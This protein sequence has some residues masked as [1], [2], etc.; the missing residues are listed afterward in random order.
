LQS[1]LC[2]F[3]RC[4]RGK[5]NRDRVQGTSQSK[6]AG[7]AALCQ[8]THLP[9]LRFGRRSPK[10]HAKRDRNLRAAQRRRPRS[11]ARASWRCFRP[12][13]R[14]D[15][16]RLQSSSWTSR[17]PSALLQEEDAH[18]PATF[19]WRGLR[20][21]VALDFV[22]C[23]V[24]DW[25]KLERPGGRG[26]GGGTCSDCTCGSMRIRHTYADQRIARCEGLGTDNQGVQEGLR[27]CFSRIQQRGSS[28]MQRPG[29]RAEALL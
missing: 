28:A 29:M 3:A 19:L 10:G 24:L 15:P 8:H 27:E 17:A 4:A 25:H 11:S 2:W 12:R 1:A 22:H 16:T 18:R 5:F 14:W 26:C 9:D 13:P 23:L 20:G 6:A 21:T 7:R